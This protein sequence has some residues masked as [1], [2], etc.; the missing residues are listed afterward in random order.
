METVYEYNNAIWVTKITLREIATPKN[1][2]QSFQY[3]YDPLGNRLSVTDEA[4]MTDYYVNNLNQYTQVGANT[5]L[6]NMIESE[7]L[8]CSVS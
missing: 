7:P 5:D 3:G 8:N 6:N 2:L 1:V 4:S